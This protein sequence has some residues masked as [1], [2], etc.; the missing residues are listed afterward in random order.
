M[1]TDFVKLCSGSGSYG[2]VYFMDLSPSVEQLRKISDGILSDA[3]CGNVFRVK[4]FTFCDDSWYEVNAVRGKI[5]I[6][7]IKNGQP[8]IIVIGECLDKEHIGSYFQFIK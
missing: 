7:K 2:S 6:S 1:G 3:R 4:G 8:I 5:V